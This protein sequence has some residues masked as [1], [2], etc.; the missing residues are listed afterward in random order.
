MCVCVCV[1]VCELARAGAYMRACVCVCGGGWLRSCVRARAHVFLCADVFVS[2]CEFVW[3]FSVSVLNQ[4]SK[5]V[6]TT[7]VFL[8]TY[9]PVK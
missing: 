9:I 6:G 2:V 8:C 5:R 4:A 7:Y 3:C 1:C